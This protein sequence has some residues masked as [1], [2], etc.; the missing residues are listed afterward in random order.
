MGDELREQ[1]ERL[2]GDLREAL[3]ELGGLT[4]R[5]PSEV[6]A[7]RTLRFSLRYSIVMAVEAAAD[8]ALLILEKVYG[9]EASSYREA[10][11]KLARRGVISAETLEGMTRLVG[12]GNMIVHRYWEVDDARILREARGGGLR[13]LER[14]LEEVSR[15]AEAL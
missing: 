3:E 6:L 4:E 9:E 1:L 13:V 11:L 14:F 15:F 2:L 12:L 8:A 7:S 5:D 10:F